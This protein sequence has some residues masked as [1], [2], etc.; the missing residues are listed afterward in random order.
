MVEDVRLS[1]NGRVP[2]E[3]FGRA[4]GMFPT[5]NQ[6]LGKLREISEKEN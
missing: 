6:I 3:F 1:V 4:G 2:V 5:V